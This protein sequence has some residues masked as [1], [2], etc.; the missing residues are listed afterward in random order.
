MLHALVMTLD[1]T[2]TVSFWE[3]APLSL[4]INDARSLIE[5]GEEWKALR[6]QVRALAVVVLVTGHRPRLIPFAG[7]TESASRA[8]E[9]G[10]F[11]LGC[12][13]TALM[14]PEGQ[15]GATWL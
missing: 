7:S 3:S 6:P 12:S 9:F 13:E 5:Q 2:G 14:L 4:S 11:D 15:T 1:A 10:K 8:W